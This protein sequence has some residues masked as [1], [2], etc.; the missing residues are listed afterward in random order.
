VSDVFVVTVKYA[1]QEVQD[2]VRC[3]TRPVAA[4]TAAVVASSPRADGQR[5]VMVGIV[6]ESQDTDP[7]ADRAPLEPVA[8]LEPA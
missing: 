7:A 6:V 4:H 5:P 8:R 3:P 2:V 1:G